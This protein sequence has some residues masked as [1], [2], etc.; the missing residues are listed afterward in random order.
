[1]PEYR[2]RVQTPFRSWS[3]NPYVY[4][5]MT[6]SL[7]VCMKPSGGYFL[8]RLKAVINFLSKLYFHLMSWRKPST[9]EATIGSAT[10]AAYR[11]RFPWVLVLRR[12]AAVAA[13]YSI[14][15]CK[16]L[17]SRILFIAAG[18]QAVQLP[19]STYGSAGRANPMQF[20]RCA[21]T[22]WTSK[23]IKM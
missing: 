7:W 5:F 15:K 22:L 16:G 17:R 6:C 10:I 18:A 13:W 11:V 3:W 2:S 9:W 23:V 14:T 12:I 19:E 21:P 20:L 1:M 4:P 8:V